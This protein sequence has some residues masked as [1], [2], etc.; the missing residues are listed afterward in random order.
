MARAW[1]RWPETRS[2]VLLSLVHQ[3]TNDFCMF[4]V[5]DWQR[6][7]SN[8]EPAVS[9]KPRVCESKEHGRGSAHATQVIRDVIELTLLDVEHM[10]PEILP[11]SILVGGQHPLCLL[12]FS[13]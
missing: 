7:I 10:D 2:K 11:E 13:L 1:R 3:Y 5:W 6:K 8:F 4:W 12:D 9:S